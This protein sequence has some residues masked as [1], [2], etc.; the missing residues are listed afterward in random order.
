MLATDRGVWAVKVSIAGLFAT[1]LLQGVVVLFSGSAALLADTLH[2]F[3]D[4]ATG[5]PLLIAFV[6]SRRAANRRYTYGYHRAEDLAGIAVLLA[7]LASAALAAWE[8]YQKLIH[9]QAPEHMEVAML[10]AF[11]GFLGNEGV[12]RLRIKVGN[13]IGSAALVADGHHART[14]SF[15]SLGALLGIFGAYVGFPIADPVA[16]LVISALI[17][18]IV[19]REAGPP[20]LARLMDAVEPE[21]VAGIEREAKGVAGVQQVHSVRA[22]WL[23]HQ[24]RAE[25]EIGV[26]GAL[27]VAQGHAIAE[28]VRHALLHQIP[29]MAEAA[30]HVDPSTEDGAHA[31]TAHHFDGSGHEDEHDHGHDGHAHRDEPDHPD[32][33]ED[34]HAHQPAVHAHDGPDGHDHADDAA[35]PQPQP[36]AAGGA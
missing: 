14:D 34:A 6:L 35:H 12:A 11:I 19:I 25:L 22:R 31:L 29:R 21:G 30:V 20:V 23:G 33:G 5:I 28:Q 26:D 8:S 10:A 16:G 13:E 17:L 18:L 15:T 36:G 27:S 32:H 3:G 24:V 7:I 9:L 2:N 4:A 1:A